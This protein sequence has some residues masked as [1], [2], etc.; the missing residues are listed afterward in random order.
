MPV[1]TD[2]N[3]V[4]LWVVLL[5]VFSIS[6]VG[7]FDPSVEYGEIF[8]YNESGFVVDLTDPE[9]YVNVTGFSMGDFR[10]VKMFDGAGFIISEPGFYQI[11]GTISFSG[12]AGGDYGLIVA[13]NFDINSSR[14]CY[15]RRSTSGGAIGN[16][17]ISCIDYYASEDVITFMMDDEGDP[18]FD[19]SIYM[20]NVN[21]HYLGD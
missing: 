15:V 16:V 14:N 12:G 7:L 18:V 2:S 11:D 3:V 13:K 6:I 20:A 17:G 5:F 10:G 1:D 21:I 19:P 4:A 8:I 9:V